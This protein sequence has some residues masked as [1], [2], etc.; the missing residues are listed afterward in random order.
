ME[1]N[2]EP[3][4]AIYCHGLMVFDFDENY[5]HVNVGVHTQAT[6]HKVKVSI[7]LLPDS[8][9]E[10]LEFEFD[11]T[12]VSK[13]KHYWVYVP[14]DNG[15]YL[16]INNAVS[17]PED[18]SDNDF[19][20]IINLESPDFFGR[21]D[22]TF[23]EKVL[24]SIIHIANGEFYADGESEV[25]KCRR[26]S[27]D[28]QLTLQKVLLKADPSEVDGIAGTALKELKSSHC[29][30]GDRPSRVKVTMH[31]T[32]DQQHLIL[33]MGDNQRPKLELYRLSPSQGKQYIIT[34]ENL[35]PHGDGHHASHTTP[36]ELK[37]ARALWRLQTNGVVTEQHSLHYYDAFKET[38]NLEPKYVILEDREPAPDLGQPDVYPAPPCF[39]TRRYLPGED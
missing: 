4:V 20:R 36:P 3:N 38:E 35:P 19:R 32:P 39:T 31:L 13:Y 37:G 34:F 1:H 5:Q 11:H 8:P 17:V 30:L 21:R 22:L 2:A 9:Y 15:G 29:S 27:L 28:S 26:V 16:P 24:E 25:R 10:P 12:S 14:D 18:S 7:W 23:N 33:A 6:G